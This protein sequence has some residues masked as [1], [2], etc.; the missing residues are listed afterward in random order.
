MATE[1]KVFGQQRDSSAIRAGALAGVLGGVV[2]GLLVQ[3]GL[4]RMGTIGAMYTLGEP[5]V[6]VGWAAH[7]VHSVL[8]GA[9]F[10]LLVDRPLFDRLAAAPLGAVGLGLGFGATLWAVNIVVLWP[11]WLNAVSAPDAPGL[12]FLALLPLVGHLVY[13]GLTGGL[14]SLTR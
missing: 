3:F 5:S 6:S 4:H 11:L 13:G 9:L 8:F 2:F 7:A 12:P 10:G 1:S 14:F